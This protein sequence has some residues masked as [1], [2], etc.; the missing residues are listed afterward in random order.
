MNQRDGGWRGRSISTLIGFCLLL[1]G[2]LVVVCASS[3][4]AEVLVDTGAGQPIHLMVNRLAKL[5]ASS[6]VSR[7]HIVNPAIAELVYSSTQSPQWIF[8][9]GKSV[10]TTQLTLWDVNNSI[11]GSFDVIVAADATGLKKSLHEIFPRENV[12]VQT[13]GDKIV[14]SGKIGRAHV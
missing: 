5:K 12:K 4:R 14:L 7:A 3:V 8:V 13:S 2:C 1:V 6:L 11:I 9:S 10:G